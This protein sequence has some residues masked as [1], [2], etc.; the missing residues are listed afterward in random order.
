MKKASAIVFCLCV[1]LFY[2]KGEGSASTASFY[3]KMALFSKLHFILRLSFFITLG[4]L[5]NLASALSK[6]SAS[7]ILASMLS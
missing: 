6:F 2:S 7:S 5:F 1:L 3:I 4:R